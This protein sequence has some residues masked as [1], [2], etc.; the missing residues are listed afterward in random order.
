MNKFFEDC[1]EAAGLALAILGFVYFLATPEVLA[2]PAREPATENTLVTEDQQDFT[3]VMLENWGSD[4][5]LQLEQLVWSSES[6]TCIAKTT[7]VAEG[8]EVTAA[9]LESLVLTGDNQLIFIPATAHVNGVWM[10]IDTFVDLLDDGCWF[11]PEF[12]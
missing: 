2:E 8:D 3:K 5:H 7:V 4:E 9:A 12:S 10:E 1:F 11:G 6:Q